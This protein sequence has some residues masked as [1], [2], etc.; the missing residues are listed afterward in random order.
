MFAA[1]T[2]YIYI[3]IF[4]NE[5]FLA[6]CF[7]A[8]D[9]IALATLDTIGTSSLVAAIASIYTDSATA[10]ITLITHKSTASIA[11]IA[12]TASTTFYLDAIQ[13]S[14]FCT[15][16]TPLQE[17]MSF[18]FME[19]FTAAKKMSRAIITGMVLISGWIHP[20]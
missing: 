20:H 1:H 18:L 16:S 15:A 7:V 17:T 11:C 6:V 2:T 9:N 13:T 12:R 10:M 14:F 3:I 4:P 8:T 19:F 5:T